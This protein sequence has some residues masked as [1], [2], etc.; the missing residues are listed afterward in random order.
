MWGIKNPLHV[1]EYITDI[2]RENNLTVNAIM[3][4]EKYKSFPESDRQAIESISV[5]NFTINDI[6]VKSP[7]NPARLLNAKLIKFIN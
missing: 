7:N 6:E 4:T 5:D 3:L 2:E 1:F